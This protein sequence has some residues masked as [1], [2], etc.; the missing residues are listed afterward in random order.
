MSAPKVISTNTF[1]IMLTAFFCLTKPGLKQGE[2]AFHK[3]NHGC[4]QDDPNRYQ[5][6][7]KVLAKSIIFIP[8][9]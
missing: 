2:A 5:V 6:P 4:R 3:Q 9:F 1:M 8:C 7:W